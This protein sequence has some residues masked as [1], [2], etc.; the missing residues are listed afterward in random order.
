MAK[1]EFNNAMS[2]LFNE[3][4][5]S[6]NRIGY[7]RT[8]TAIKEARENFDP[9]P[10]QHRLLKKFI[11]RETC[12]AFGVPVTKLKNNKS[13]GNRSY[14]I[15]VISALFKKHLD[16][17][18]KE[19]HAVLDVHYTHISRL[20]SQFNTLNEKN[21]TQGR[22]KMNYLDLDKM[23]TEFKKKNILESANEPES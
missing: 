3:M 18:L 14:C 10:E 23:V 19:T 9:A 13:R 4:A 11:I 12:I 8:K 7:Q 21:K 15:M 17:N 22:I 5:E 16:Y 6:L 2:E 20:L 1:E